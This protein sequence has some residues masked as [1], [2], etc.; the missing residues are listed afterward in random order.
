MLSTFNS[1]VYGCG[2]QSFRING[3][4]ELSEWLSKLLVRQDLLIKVNQMTIP[5]SHAYK[6]I[7]L[8]R[9]LAWCPLCL[10]EQEKAGDDMHYPLLW[11][12]KNYTFCHKHEV[13]LFDQCPNCSKYQPVMAFH[14]HPGRC[15]HCFS[16]LGGSGGGYPYGYQKEMWRRELNNSIAGIVMRRRYSQVIE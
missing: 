11:M 3:R 5:K 8:R 9:H 1:Y 6:A 13:P 2:L 12:P 7:D 15:A 16:F 14:N 10:Q 4:T